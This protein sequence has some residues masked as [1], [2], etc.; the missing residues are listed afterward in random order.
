MFKSMDL[1]KGIVLVCLLLL[2]VSL[3]YLWYVRGQRTAAFAAVDAAEKSK[4]ELDKI[5]EAIRKLETVA[6]NSSRG[7][8]AESYRLY[9]ERW[10]TGSAKSG[11]ST[12]DFQLTNETPSAVPNNAK[13]EDLTVGVAFK[14]AGKEFDLPRD[15][16][17]AVALN[18]ESGGSQ[19][20]KL[21]TLKMR[22]A[23]VLELTKQKKAPPKTVGDNWK[24]ERLE[25]ARRR[26][27]QRAS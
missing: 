11:I 14:R 7:G 26:P 13:A 17:H 22:N 19:I 27:K 12:N 18:C 20:W 4:G 21:R 3:G 5:G 10:I 6:S 15:F 1:Y 2:P 8:D 9:F 16:I 23:D 25:F 24:L